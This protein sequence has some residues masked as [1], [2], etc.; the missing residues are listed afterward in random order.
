[1]LKFGSLH[2]RL[3]YVLEILFIAG[4]Y[5]ILARLS[6]ILQFKSSNATP[7]WPP[8]GFAFAIILLLGYRIAPGIMLGAFAANVFIFLSNKTCGLGTA[9]WL[10]FVI[11]IGNTS[12]SLVGYYFLNKIIPNARIKNVFLNVNH[13]FRFS[14]VTGLMCLVSCSIGTTAVFLAKTI[15]ANQYSIVWLTWW[16]GDVS[17]ILLVMPFILMWTKSFQSPSTIFV[18]SWKR[19]AEAMTLFLTVF[20]C[21]GYIFDN[22]FFSL[23]VFKWAFWIIPILVW[24]AVR[25]NQRE[26]ITA[27]ILCSAVAIWGTV[28]KQGPFAPLS[29]N[30]SLLTVQAFVSIMVITQLILNASIYQR[31]QTEARLRSLSNELEIRVQK[32]TAELAY[33]ANELAEKNKELEK[34]NEELGSFTY[35]ASHDL[36]EP[37]RK[38][39]MFAKLILE[40]EIEALSEKGKDYFN[41]MQI[42]TQRMQ[43][44]IEDLLSYSHTADT[45]QKHFQKTDLNVLIEHVK[46]E[47]KEKITETNTV[48]ET[49]ELPDL[50]VIPFQFHQLFTNMISNS[51]KF[52]KPGIP[53]L[54]RIKSTVINR[55]QIT[56]VNGVTGENY[57]HFTISDNGIGFQP[58]FNEKIFGLFQRLHAHNEYP[59]TGIGLSIC[60]KIIENHRGI[61]TANGEP[62]NGATFNI[63]LPTS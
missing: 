12:E 11:S 4:V 7:V 34:M 47:L 14:F 35:S 10:S 32:R 3:R 51:I 21:S 50:H 26:T 49:A 2:L 44:L 5:F 19:K 15:T 56:D 16:L 61:L 41:R 62:D 9:I 38:I 13:I 29:V 25:F 22:W 63:Y 60:K 27:I 6:L 20:L 28:N 39:Q 53:P 18:G 17:G 45:S 40:K 33:S 58:N 52:S 59:G 37:L 43:Q 57:Y 24:A 31:R 55:A 42:A 8:S 30:E 36:Q 48:I 54:I 23:S 1:M 46:T